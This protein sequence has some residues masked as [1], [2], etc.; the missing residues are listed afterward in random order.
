MA[1]SSDEQQI[2]GNPE[3]NQQTSARFGNR[4]HGK[5]ERVILCFRMVITTLG[6]CGES[7]LASV[8]NAVCRKVFVD[9]LQHIHRIGA[10][11]ENSAAGA[12]E[13]YVRSTGTGLIKLPIQETARRVRAGIRQVENKAER[14]NT[15]KNSN[16]GTTAC[17][18]PGI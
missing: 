16:R 3:T 5:I 6:I 12:C 11:V 14:G 17:A 4:A 8:Q 9:D 2:A 18:R 13:R 7:V 1:D 10:D 15:F